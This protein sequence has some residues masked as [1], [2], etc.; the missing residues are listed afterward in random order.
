MATLM[1]SDDAL[2]AAVVLIL[3][4]TMCSTCVR[5]RGAPSS[6]PEAALDGAG[7]LLGP[8]ESLH[9]VP[10]RGRSQAIIVFVPGNP[11][12]PHFYLQ[13]ARTLSERCGVEIVLLGL[14]GHITSAAAA[15]LNADDRA[16]TFGI[17]EQVE[18][19]A[20]RTV[21]HMRRAKRL[22]VPVC[23]VGHSIGGWIALEAACVL[24]AIPM[25][26]M[27]VGGTRRSTRRQS[28]RTVSPCRDRES[29]E[30]LP[31]A[32]VDLH[33]LAM[34]PFLSTA[35]DEC[36]AAVTEKLRAVNMLG[37]RFAVLAGGLG[38]LLHRTPRALLRWLLAGEIRSLRPPVGAFVLDEV[39]HATSL[40][41]MAHLAQS[42]M[43]ALARPYDFDR[44]ASPLA[45]AR[46]LHL[47]YVENDQWA[48]VAMAHRA[49]ESGVPCDILRDQTGAAPMAHAFSVQR[50]E[51]CGARVTD[52]CA[53]WIQRVLELGP[54]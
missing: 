1:E 20:A 28:R 27:G 22:G 24:G 45:A 6:D 44:A 23:L 39:V 51:A 46:R 35:P 40:R 34:M 29:D 42:E 7:S 21:P 41:N 26:V 54:R 16:R 3:A 5:W 14:A 48:P 49:A 15:Q 33:V 36:T 19:V 43:N 9:L 18:H 37:G 25:P 47:L 12:H 38:A 52:W 17:R 8:Y 4:L 13:F 53:A 10:K 32:D 30:A 2:V 11:G 50:E 31:D